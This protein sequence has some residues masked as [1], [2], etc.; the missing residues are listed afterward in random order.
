M[1]MDLDEFVQVPILLINF[2]NQRPQ[3]QLFANLPSD[4]RHRSTF[5]SHETEL[6]QP[7]HGAV[8]FSQA[9]RMKLLVISNTKRNAPNA[10]L[11]FSA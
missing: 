2:C 5:E 3:Q 10:I 8:E 11:A 4:P 7:S 1:D 9:G 6:G